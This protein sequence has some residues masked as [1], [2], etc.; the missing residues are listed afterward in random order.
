MSIWTLLTENTA[1]C[2]S[3][4]FKILMRLE[5]MPAEDMDVIAADRVREF[6]EMDELG[7]RDRVIGWD[8]E[9]LI[10]EGPGSDEP[11]LT[12][13]RS[14]LDDD[15]LFELDDGGLIRFS[16]CRRLQ[17]QTRTTSFSI[18]NRFAYDAISS[19]VGFELVRKLFSR[20]TRIEVSMLVR[21]LRRL[22]TPSG[23]CPSD[24]DDGVCC[25]ESASSSHFWSSGF[26]LHMFLKLR[27]SAS[28][29]EMVVWLKSLPY[30]LPIARPTS[31]WVKPAREKN[32]NKKNTK[33]NMKFF[34]PLTSA[35]C[36][37]LLTEEKTRLKNRAQMKYVLFTVTYVREETTLPIQ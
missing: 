29:R 36:W 37:S 8:A 9:A 7:T 10:A 32:K 28:K 1:C 19:E 34:T 16:F 22:A 11:L 27:L 23:S 13:M 2:K 35:E 33:T 24:N 30:S 31:P 4:A 21:F 17:N 26:S 25:M 14:G 5:L 6:E 12:V 15:V 18:C 20:A 3:L